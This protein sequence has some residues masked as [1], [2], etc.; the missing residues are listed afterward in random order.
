MNNSIDVKLGVCG[1]FERE[2]TQAAY[3]AEWLNSDDMRVLSGDYSKVDAPFS[4]KELKIEARYAA[5]KKAENKIMGF[6]AS[7]DPNFVISCAVAQ[8]AKCSRYDVLEIFTN[9]NR[10]EAVN[11]QTNEKFTGEF[12]ILNSLVRFVFD[13]AKA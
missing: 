7:K 8:F 3:Q 6:L 4:S 11:D 9:G 5:S 13:G 1:K 12:M 2:H 10:F